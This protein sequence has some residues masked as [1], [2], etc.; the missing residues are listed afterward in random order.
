MISGVAF[1][2]R[3]KETRIICVSQRG[4]DMSPFRLS[5]I[6]HSAY[7]RSCGMSVWID[8]SSGKTWGEAYFNKCKPSDISYC[9]TNGRR[10]K[11][12]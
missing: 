7:C 4:H 12:I 2:K 6:G 10:S 9:M 5:M 11:K 3:K 1:D 8:R